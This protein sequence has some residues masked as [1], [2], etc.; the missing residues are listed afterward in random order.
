[1]S[2]NLTAEFGTF[3][4]GH[5][6]IAA[7]RRADAM[8]ITNQLSVEPTYSFNHVTLVQGEFTT[9]LAGSRVTYTMTP[10]MFVSALL[11]YN[12][13]TDVGLDQRAAPVGIPARQRAV[14]RLQRGAQHLDAKLSLPQQPRV[15]REDQSAVSRLGRDR[16]IHSPFVE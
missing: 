5:K 15:H 2:A 13:G 12:S 3:Y 9:H 8:P 10:L 16:N 7:A 11:Q 1:M 14:R 4:N 6:T